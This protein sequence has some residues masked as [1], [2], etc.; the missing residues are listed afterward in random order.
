MSNAAAPFRAELDN[1]D[2]ASDHRSLS[3]LAVVNASLPSRIQGAATWGRF[4]LL[5]PNRPT[6]RNNPPE[7]KTH[8]PDVFGCVRLVFGHVAMT[9]DKMPKKSC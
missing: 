8:K 2:A 1:D 5:V 9:D 6:L 7:P 3:V 4:A